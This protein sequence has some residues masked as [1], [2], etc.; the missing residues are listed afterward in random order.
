MKVLDMRPSRKSALRVVRGKSAMVRSWIV[1]YQVPKTTPD[2]PAAPRPAYTMCSRSTGRL[3]SYR[4]GG[5]LR[6]I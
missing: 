6:T 1:R 5:S 4:S 3:V 2:E